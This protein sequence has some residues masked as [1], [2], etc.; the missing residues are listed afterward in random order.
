MAIV[1]VVIVV[2]VVVVILMVVVVPAIVPIVAV[3]VPLVIVFNTAAIP[4]PVSCK[5]LL[6][7]VVRSDPSCPFIRRSRPITVMPLIVMP[8]GIPITVNISVTGTRAA[9]HNVNH[10]RA[11]RRT[12]INAERDLRLRYRCAGEQRDD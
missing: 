1:V 11:W 12:D 9:R 10:T 5:K 4:F 3:L 2:I 8:G 7:I 6:S